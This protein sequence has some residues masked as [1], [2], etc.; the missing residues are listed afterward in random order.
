VTGFLIRDR[1]GVYCRVCA[2]LDG[3]HIVTCPVVTLEG[4]VKDLAAHLGIFMASVRETLDAID[5]ITT[6]RPAE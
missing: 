5:Q 2:G 1:R 4:H 6:G 3:R